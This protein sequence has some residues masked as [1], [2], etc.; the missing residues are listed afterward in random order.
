MVQLP[1]LLRLP[2]WTRQS[3]DPS[4]WIAPTHESQ[5]IVSEDFQEPQSLLVSEKVLQCTSNLH[6]RPPFLLLYLP[7]FEALKKG[8]PKQY[9]SHLHC[10]VPPICT[11]VRLHLYG[12]AFE[13]V[14]GLGLP[15]SSWL[16]PILNMACGS[17]N[18]PEAP[19]PRKAQSSNRWKV[20]QKWV[21]WK[22]GK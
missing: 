16:L 7:G 9:A 1:L 8:K 5:Y 20:S 6:G 17:A 15:E 14:Q 22:S 4:L 11:A 19:K 3:Q 12:S 10:S 13:K 18:L 21:F 2:L